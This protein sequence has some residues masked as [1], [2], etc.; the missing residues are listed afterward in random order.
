MELIQLTLGNHQM[1]SNCYIIINDGEAVVI[2][3]GF[4]DSKL[5][6][7]LKNKNLN[8][9]KIILTHG[10]F[11]HWGGLKKLQYLYPKAILYASTLDYIWYE[12]GPN[13]YY[14]YTPTIDVDLNKIKE[15]EIFESVFKILK[16]PGH[17]AGSVALYNQKEDKIISGDVLF[18]GGVGRYDL[19]QGDF[20]TLTFSIKSL[21]KLPGNTIVYS[22][23]GRPTT[24]EF[25]KQN[26]PFIKG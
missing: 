18:Y 19:A 2:D 22:G 14:N 20:K 4:E 23:H 17:S 3:P 16:V 10:H 24:I 6:D 26:N 15:L 1:S 11:D 9:T 8:V 13:N 5:Y 12:I 7:Y 21:Y 25:E